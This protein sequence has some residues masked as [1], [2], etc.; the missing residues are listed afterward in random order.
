VQ[1]P[2][3]ANHPAPDLDVIA[4][5]WLNAEV[6]DDASVNRDATG[7]D[8]LIAMSA[9]SDASGCEKAI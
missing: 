3:G 6:G 8:Q 4:F 1:L 7:R 5:R 9:R 2:F